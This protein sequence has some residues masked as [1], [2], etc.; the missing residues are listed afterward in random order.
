MESIQLEDTL[1]LTGDEPVLSE[2][3]VMLAEKRIK[4]YVHF[5]GNRILDGI[6]DSRGAGLLENIL[7]EAGV[8]FI[9]ADK[10]RRVLAFQEGK[11]VVFESGKSI[12]CRE[13][14]S[15]ERRLSY[16]NILEPTGIR[17]QHGILVNE[18]LQT[19]DSSVFALGEMVQYGTEAFSASAA[20]DKQARCLAAYFH[21]NLSQ[22]YDGSPPRHS[23]SLMTG[24]GKKRCSISVMGEV[25]TEDTEDIEEVFFLDPQRH[26]YKKCCIHTGRLIG[27]IFIGEQEAESYYWN[28]IDQKT[29]LD[30]LREKLLQPGIRVSNGEARMV[31]SCMQIREDEIFDAIANGCTAVGEL[32]ERLGAGTKCGSCKPELAGILKKRGGLLPR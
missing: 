30:G 1:L 31:C 7:A 12:V 29:E 13:I 10:I 28:L 14:I 4:V 24:D 27:A 2:A 3:A 17:V 22:C 11:K 19:N 9:K 8:K 6:L 5:E 25:R 32:C 26:V 15:F 21:G 20:A 23:W 18:Y 16:L